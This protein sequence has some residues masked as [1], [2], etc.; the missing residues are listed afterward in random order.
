MCLLACQ[1]E[2]ASKT[3]HRTVYIHTRYFNEKKKPIGYVDFEHD[4]LYTNIVH[5]AS[6]YKE[7]FLST[8]RSTLHELFLAFFLVFYGFRFGME[9]TA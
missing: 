4:N 2:K 6:L 1:C 8:R 9:M 3:R 7:S 5:R